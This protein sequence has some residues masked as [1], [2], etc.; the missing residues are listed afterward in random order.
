LPSQGLW[1]PKNQKIYK[2][3]DGVMPRIVAS[4]SESD[5]CVR[6]GMLNTYASESIVDCMDKL[7]SHVRV[8]WVL[9]KSDFFR[10]EHFITLPQA[11]TD[12]MVFEVS[13]D[14]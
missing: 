4:A 5:L 14:P 8:S 3:P 13:S 10:W 11:R 2:K 6:N 1:Q 7:T 9:K 12:S